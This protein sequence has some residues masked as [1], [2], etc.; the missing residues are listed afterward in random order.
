[1]IS[2]D[3]PFWN[4]HSVLSLKSE[5][6]DE[7]ENL[8]CFNLVMSNILAEVMR[9]P[10]IERL[11]QDGDSESQ[12]KV[13]REF[14]VKWF[15]DKLPQSTEVIVMALSDSIRA[16]PLEDADIDMFD[17][18]IVGILVSGN[19]KNIYFRSHGPYSKFAT[20]GKKWI[21]AGLKCGVDV[22]T[23]CNDRPL[24]YDIAFPTPPEKNDLETGPWDSKPRAGQV[25]DREA[26]QFIK[27]D[28]KGH[29]IF[30]PCDGR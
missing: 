11:L 17:D 28:G 23:R 6:S 10:E 13:K 12:R 1:M 30:D 4:D 20:V 19:Y 18:A 21:A 29:R 25:I 24:S 16:L 15:Q 7:F 5:G 8:E 26:C 3:S 14:F 22:Y 2:Y 9:E 27:D